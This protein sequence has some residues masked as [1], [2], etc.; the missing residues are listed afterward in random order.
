VHLQRPNPVAGFWNAVQARDNG[1]AWLL[2]GMDSQSRLISI[3][4][5][6]RVLQVA[7]RHLDRDP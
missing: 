7:K 2:A 5:D 1:T 6:D 3:D 4:A